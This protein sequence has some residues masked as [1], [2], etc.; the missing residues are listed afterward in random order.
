MPSTSTARPFADRR[1]LH[2]ELRIDPSRILGLVEIHE[3]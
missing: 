2:V 3:L 1:T